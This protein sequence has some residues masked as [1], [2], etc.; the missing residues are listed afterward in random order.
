[1]WL[2]RLLDLMFPPEPEPPMW[3]PLLREFIWSHAKDDA[4]DRIELPREDYEAVLAELRPSLQHLRHPENPKYNGAIS[5]L[6]CGFLVTP[7]DSLAT[8]D[9]RIK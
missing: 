3:E 7:N 5:F 8:G 2:R 6:Y 1:M 4:A 9:W